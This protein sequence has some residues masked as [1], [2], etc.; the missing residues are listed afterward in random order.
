MQQEA[1]KNNMGEK[2]AVWNHYSNHNQKGIFE[3]YSKFVSA[4]PPASL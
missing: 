3:T 4:F 2:T 1:D